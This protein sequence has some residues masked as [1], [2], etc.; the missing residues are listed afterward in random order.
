MANVALGQFLEAVG[1]VLAF[2]G[3]ACSVALDRLSQNDRGSAVALSGPAVSRIHLE[4]V[5]A[6]AGELLELRVAE[7]AD[8]V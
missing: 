7:V 1:G 3:F 2:A 8:Q 4:R 6:S 5:V